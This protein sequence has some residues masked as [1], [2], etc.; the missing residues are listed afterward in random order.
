MNGS[1]E[2]R[3]NE[4]V[5]VG[6][7]DDFHRFLSLIHA[8]IEKANYSDVVLNLEKCTAA[9]QNSMLS[10]CAQVMA[11]RKSGVEFSLI[12]PEFPTLRNI[13]RN[14]GWGFFWIRRILIPQIFVDIQ[15]FPL[16]NIKHQMNSNQL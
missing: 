8:A 5:V 7:V 4:I 12:P 10:V 16:H 11:Y 9:F 15:E 14:T 2:R 13:F 6:E 1:I 3:E